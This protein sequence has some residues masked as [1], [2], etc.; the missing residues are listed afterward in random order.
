MIYIDDFYISKLKIKSLKILK[1]IAVLCLLFS[2]VKNTHENISKVSKNITYDKAVIFYEKGQQDSAYLYFERA[3]SVFAAKRETLGVV[4][5]LQYM[6]ITSTDVGDHYGSQELASETLN[7]LDTKNKNHFPYLQSSY[8]TL[9]MAADNLKEYKQ[10]LIFYQMALKYAKGNEYELIIENNVANAYRHLKEY[11]KAIDIY[12]KIITR[13]KKE[14]SFYA[15]VLTNLSTAKWLKDSA[16]DSS[17]EL[18]K[19]L[20]IREKENDL[21]GQHSSNSHLSEYYAEKRPD[22]ALYYA[23]I[24]YGLSK[25][26]ESPDNQL[27]ALKKLIQMSSI[28]DS[29]NYF[30]RYQLLL[31]SISTSRNSS[32]N[33]F[34]LIRYETEKHKANNLVLQKKN[35]EK[36]YQISMLI[37]GTGLLGLGS[38]FWYRKRRERLSLE[39]KNSIRESQLKTSKKVHDKVAN[40]IYRVMSEVENKDDLDRNHLLDQLEHIY[41]TSRDI[42]YEIT[43]SQPS[44]TF[45]Q[46]LSAMFSAYISNTRS[47]EVI[48]NDDDLWANVPEYKKAEVFIILLELMT[49]VKKHSQAT[50]VKIRFHKSQNTISVNYHDNGTGLPKNVIYNNGLKNTETRIKNISG[51][52]TFESTDKSGL[53]IL[54]SFAAN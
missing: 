26:I 37:T 45:S 34:A 21:W 22:S 46:Q 8:S 3:K 32:K 47:V 27:E 17:F 16:Y 11:N 29:K 41:N 53:E 20:K 13:N 50:L 4:K 25:R 5:C 19:A 33:Q 14:D 48:N 36:N 52:I 44:I 12:K 15:Q 38:W 28:I 2:C 10:A 54:I 6:A 7:L 42:S 39:A 49:N 23:K 35:T 43:D 9:G 18:I 40:K 51:T 31:D 30:S 24:T 1:I